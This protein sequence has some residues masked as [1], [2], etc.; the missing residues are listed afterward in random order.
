[1]KRIATLVLAVGAALVLNASAAEA[2]AKS[3]GLYFGVG[4]GATIPTGDAG[5]VLKTGWNA[6]AQVGYEMPSG[7]G[8][9]GD[10]IYGQHGLDAGGDEKLKLAGGLGNVTYTFKSASKIHPYLV[11]SVG[12][13]SAKFADESDSDLAFGGGVGILVHTGSD[14]NFFLEGRYITINGDPSNTNIIPIQVGI[15]FGL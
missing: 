7:L 11:G 1:M 13:M 15:R 3:G 10:F 6:L 4:A 9:R 12:I 5:D 2:Q 8:L 14:S